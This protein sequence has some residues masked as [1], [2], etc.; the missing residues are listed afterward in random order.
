M[1]QKNGGGLHVS[2]LAILSSRCDG[3]KL[4]QAARL[5]MKRLLT[6]GKRL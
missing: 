5:R 4:G 2:I 6:A 1:Y 3:E